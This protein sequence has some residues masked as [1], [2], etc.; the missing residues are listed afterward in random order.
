MQARTIGAPSANAALK[1]KFRGFVSRADH[2][3]G[4]AASII[5]HPFCSGAGDPHNGM[6]RLPCVDE[7]E[8]GELVS[9]T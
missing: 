1:S 8:T 9:L 5:S 7:V 2:Q 4:A 6:A 3:R